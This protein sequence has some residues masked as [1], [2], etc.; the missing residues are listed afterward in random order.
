MECMEVLEWS[1]HPTLP[2]SMSVD[3][4]WH[5]KAWRSDVR[6][7]TTSTQFM[8]L[9]TAASVKHGGTLWKVHLSHGCDVL[10]NSTASNQNAVFNKGLL[11]SK[12]AFHGQDSGVGNYEHVRML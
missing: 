1:A 2:V 4:A 10:Y 3:E 11:G 8:K 6:Y 7:R 9:R 5:H 12:S